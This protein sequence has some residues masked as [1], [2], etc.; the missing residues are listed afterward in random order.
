[1]VINSKGVIQ[2]QKGFEQKIV[3]P[4][5]RWA[6]ATPTDIDIF[7]EFSNKLWVFGEVKRDGARFGGGQELCYVRTVDALNKADKQAYYL[8]IVH[9]VSGYEP[10]HTAECIV[11][12]IYN[13]TWNQELNLPVKQVI[14]G[15]L[16]QHGLDKKFPTK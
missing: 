4:E 11:V 13:G 12:A 6:R 1:L 7:L 15:F 5:L 10:I 9:S 14:D 8:R 3:W 2:N 16:I